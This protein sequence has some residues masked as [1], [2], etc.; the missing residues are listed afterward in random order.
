MLEC[1]AASPP[2]CSEERR[3][4]AKEMGPITAPIREW[5]LSLRNAAAPVRAPHATGEP[6]THAKPAK[7]DGGG[8]SGRKGKGKGSK[9][10]KGGSSGGVSS[11]NG[12]GSGDQGPR[13]PESRQ[14][15]EVEGE[16]F[17]RGSQGEGNRRETRVNPER[18]PLVTHNL[19][20]LLSALHRWGEAGQDS[21]AGDEDV[22]T[23][24]AGDTP[25]DPRLKSE[26]GSGEKEACSG[27]EGKIEGHQ[28]RDDLARL[29]GSSGDR[30][31][32]REQNAVF[33]LAEPLLDACLGVAA[34]RASLWL[35]GSVVEAKA[36]LRRRLWS[37]EDPA[38][39][40]KQ[41]VEADVVLDAAV[42]SIKVGTVLIYM[43][44]MVLRSFLD[45]QAR[46]GYGRSESS[47]M[48]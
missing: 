16:V 22:R 14:T 8:K 40:E 44:I 3:A 30:L 37:S 24:A 23:D 47:M 12:N 28:G 21:G 6:P 33:A 26:Q 5:L 11:G 39:L 34:K 20:V 18:S 10:T 48:F 4:L 2:L 29:V 15:P 43:A 9:K 38:A 46:S 19:V 45:T 41:R 35:F 7:L 31:L 13:A 32:S 36:M 25:S 27:A 42:P 17:T 1:L